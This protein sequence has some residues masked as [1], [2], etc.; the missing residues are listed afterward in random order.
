MKI[1]WCNNGNCGNCLILMYIHYT[2][3]SFTLPQLLNI[4]RVRFPFCFLSLLYIYYRS[5]D[6]F[7]LITFYYV[8]L[9][10]GKSITSN[11]F[12]IR[13]QVWVS[14]VHWD[15]LWRNMEF[16]VISIISLFFYSWESCFFELSFPGV[17]LYYSLYDNNT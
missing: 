14:L 17:C 16:N 9:H 2:I 5:S 8:R 13:T 11:S 3:L 4:L 10:R 15:I 12:L 7:T 1:K 6:T